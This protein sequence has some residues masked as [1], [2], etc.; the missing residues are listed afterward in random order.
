MSTPSPY[1]FCALVLALVFP[2]SIALGQEGEEAAARPPADDLKWV[3]GPAVANITS[4]AEISFPEG[5]DYLDRED[6]KTLMELM[7]NPSNG[8]DYYIGREDMR[9]FAVFSYEG[10]GYIRDD[11]QIDPDELI[12]AIREG[13]EANNEIRR[14]RGWGEMNVVGWAYEPFYE[15]ES[16]RLAWAVLFESD[17]EQVINYNTRILGRTGVMA[18]TLVGDPGTLDAD[19]DEFR[20]LLTG[21]TYKAGST[22]AEFRD[23]D[24]VAA[25]G[26]A[27]L[28]AGGAAAALVKS[29]AGKGILKFIWVAIVGFFAFLVSSFKRFF[30]RNSD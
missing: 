25:Y 2:T 9:W 11:E 6:T 7:E 1:A 28:V 15:P 8:E 26:L 4:Y 20:R 24:R 29:G 10:T 18:A 22:Y 27:A 23:G 14:E 30:G 5:Y 16:N 12:E 17:G 13:S 3:V 21:F 19:V